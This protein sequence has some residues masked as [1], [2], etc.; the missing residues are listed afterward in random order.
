MSHGHVY[1]AEQSVQHWLTASNCVT[2][3]TS[4]HK[5]KNKRGEI[6][7][8]QQNFSSNTTDKKVSFIKIL[9]GGHQIP[10]KKFSMGIPTM[11]YANKEVDAPQLIWDFSE[12]LK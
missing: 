12:G 1:S 8:V 7:A 4:T 10:N 11:G 5:F 6:T 3:P 9:N 2:I